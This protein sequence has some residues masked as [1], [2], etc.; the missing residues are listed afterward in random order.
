MVHPVPAQ[1]S[2][3]AAVGRFESIFEDLKTPLHMLP[4]NR[5]IGDKPG[6]WMPAHVVTPEALAKYR[7]AFGPLW[8][9]Y[10]HH[11]CRFIPHCDPILGSGLPED[12]AQW[13]WLQSQLS[14]AR[15]RRIFFLTH[16]PLLLTHEDEPEH[17]DNLAFPARDRTVER[18]SPAVVPASDRCRPAP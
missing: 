4:G 8:S 17:Y 15:E 10:D 12:D 13:D 1:H 5:D 14:D 7:K 18:I 3:D 11:G 2:Y 6:D 16:Y 9:A